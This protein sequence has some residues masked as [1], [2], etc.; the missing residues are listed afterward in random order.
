M[1]AVNL[2]PAEE[3]RG[4]S[5]GGR[6]T[7]AA[8]AVLGVLAVLVMMAAAWTLTGKTVKDRQ[9]KLTGVEQQAGAAEAQANKLAAYSVFSDLRK[10]RAETVASIAKSRFDWA[11]VMHEVARIIPSDTHLT[12]LSGTVSPTAQ[13]PN[14]GTGQAWQLR[15]SAPGPAID[16]V[17]CSN[18]QAN[19]SR[20][21]SRLRLIDGV[22]HVTLAESTKSDTVSTGGASGG[23]NGECRYN[24]HIARFDVLVTFAAPPAVAAPAAAPAAGA[25]AIAAPA[26]TTT[27]STK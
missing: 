17:G 23:D 2:I 26:S 16:I 13:A 4:G 27:G 8:Y 24:D 14:G 25:T 22:D 21:M 19:V 9:A 12:S 20:M 3:R 1:K 18:G 15:S 11:H 10:K 7:N 5:A 6:S